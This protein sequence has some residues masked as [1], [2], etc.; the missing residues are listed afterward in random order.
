M[1]YRPIVEEADDIQRD[2]LQAVFDA[3]D[4]LATSA[5]R[6]SIFM[7]GE[8]GIRDTADALASAICTTPNACRCTRACRTASRTACSSRRRGAHCA[9]DQ[10][11]RNLADRTGH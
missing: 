11:G 5:A 3:V 8:R 1:R 2:R 4:E 9:G 7:S 10:R 6:S